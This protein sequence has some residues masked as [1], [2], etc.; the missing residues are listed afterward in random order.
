MSVVTRNAA[1]FEATGAKI[2]NPWGDPPAQ[3]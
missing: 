2:F 3:G 1:D